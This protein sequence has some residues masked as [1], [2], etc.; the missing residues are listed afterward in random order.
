MRCSVL[1]V[2]RLFAAGVVLQHSPASGVA[3]RLRRSQGASRAAASAPAPPV[4]QKRKREEDEV[5]ESEEKTT[6]DEDLAWPGGQ[7][8]GVVMGHSLVG[9]GGEGFV[10]DAV[11]LADREAD[12]DADFS[13]DCRAAV[14]K[15]PFHWS[16]L[17]PCAGSTATEVMEVARQH[18]SWRESTFFRKHKL[19]LLS[20]DSKSPEFA[21]AQR[22]LACVEPVHPRLPPRTGSRRSRQRWWWIR[23]ERRQRTSDRRQRRCSVLRARR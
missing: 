16:W 1:A 9:R 21:F 10:C 22:Y 18:L 4:G 13:K 19:C 6:T 17:A 11:R 15:V 23:G 14:L 8:R 5:D 7:L 20:G 3:I 2:S 12:E